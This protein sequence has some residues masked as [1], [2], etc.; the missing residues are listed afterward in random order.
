MFNKKRVISFLMILAMVFSFSP[1]AGLSTDAES[2]EHHVISEETTFSDATY[3][4]DNITTLE[5]DAVLT[6]KNGCK[7]N[8]CNVTFEGSGE[9]ISNERII[10]NGNVTLTVEEGVTLEAEKGIDVVEGATLTIEGEGSINA[11]GAPSQAG[12]GSGDTG[13]GCGTIIINNG[14]IIATGGD[15]GV[16]SIS[17]AAGI[18]SADITYGGSSGGNITTIGGGRQD[19]VEGAHSY[20]GAAGIGGGNGGTVDSITING[21]SITAIGGACAAS[22]GSGNCA[23]TESVNINITGGDIACNSNI[24]GACWH[25]GIL[26]EDVTITISGGKIYAPQI[27][28]GTEINGDGQVKVSIGWTNETDCITINQGGLQYVTELTLTK[29]FQK[30]GVI[31]TE[32]EL[33][34]P[35][36]PACTL[37]PPS[38]TTTVE[39]TTEAPTTVEPTTVQQT[40]EAPTVKPATPTKTTKLSIKK[41]K[42]L[43]KHKKKNI[44]KVALKIN[45]KAV[46]GKKITLKI[47][48]KTLKAKTNKKGI[49]K[50]TIKKK[51]LKKLK[52][53]KKVKLVA[54]YGK[55]KA[56]RKVKVVK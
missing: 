29:P 56:T 6:I 25:V 41:I 38:E 53:G 11:T 44:V 4:L 1:M 42:K 15:Y 27:G 10:I 52:A 7:I 26:S 19:T 45:G 9:V 18:G 28:Y 5:N 17:G 13:K 34:Q 30:D 39:P 48:G 46:K 40:T 22:I 14:N 50:F 21:G 35:D 43:K 24:G 47:K 33:I 31:V 8:D 20:Y 16:T 23:Y 3:V 54:K 37:C 51:I 12:I 49:A 36:F 2:I 55:V 32:E